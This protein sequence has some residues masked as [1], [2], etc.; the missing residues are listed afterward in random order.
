VIKNVNFK[1]KF[2]DKIK[3]DEY[4]M[5]I[6]MVYGKF[7]KKIHFNEIRNVVKKIIW[8]LAMDGINKSDPM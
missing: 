1:I 2:K 7:T 3:S 8:D 4:K 6:E 5:L